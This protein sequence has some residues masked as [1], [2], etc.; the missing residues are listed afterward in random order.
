MKTIIYVNQDWFKELHLYTIYIGTKCQIVYFSF[1]SSRLFRHTI[2]SIGVHNAPQRLIMMTQN[3]SQMHHKIVSQIW[4][5]KTT[6]K[7]EQKT[8]P[9]Q[10]QQLKTETQKSIRKKN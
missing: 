7:K 9:K 2:F 5:L 3:Q 10:K 6:K 4:K 8:N 1:S